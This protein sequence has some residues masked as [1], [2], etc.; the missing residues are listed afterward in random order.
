M[1][2]VLFDKSYE[3][4]EYFSPVIPKPGGPDSKSMEYIIKICFTELHFII[5]FSSIQPKVPF[6]NNY[7]NHNHK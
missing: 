5:P 7:R 4:L 2:P 3:V 1:Y 6:H